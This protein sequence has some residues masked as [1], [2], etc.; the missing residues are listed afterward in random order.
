MKPLLYI[1]AVTGIMVGACATTGAQPL[2]TNQ[3][4]VMSTPAP[5]LNTVNIIDDRL[6]TTTVLR[7]GEASV[8]GKLAVEGAGQKYTA[9]QTREVWATLRNLTDYPQNI[10]ARVTWFDGQNAPV[11]GPTS[12]T[13]IHLPQN[14]SEI[15]RSQS[16]SR[17]AEAFFVEIREL[18]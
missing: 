1:F 17:D 5:V 14:G 2:R 8:S 7:N 6:Q 12:W 9:T 4:V 15:Y 16:I 3:Q 18:N 11:D 13:R 10:E